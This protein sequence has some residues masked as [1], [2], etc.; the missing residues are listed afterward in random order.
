[1]K[2]IYT[3]KS[4][5]VNKLV[6]TIKSVKYKRVKRMYVS[7]EVTPTRSFQPSLK[8]LMH[9]GLTRM[10]S[11]EVLDRLDIHGKN[12]LHTYSSQL[13]HINE[14]PIAIRK[15]KSSNIIKGLKK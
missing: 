10:E 1:M 9:N 11:L 15:E 13:L 7:N 8:E 5:N 14:T 6:S 3:P 4:E 12:T 2:K